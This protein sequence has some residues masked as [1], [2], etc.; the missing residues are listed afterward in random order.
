MRSEST[1]IA[2]RWHSP[3]DQSAHCEPL[4]PDNGLRMPEEVRTGHG[5]SHTYLSGPRDVK[6]HEG[7]PAESGMTCGS[8][9]EAGLIGYRTRCLAGRV[10]WH[11]SI[12]FQWLLVGVACTG[13][14]IGADRLGAGTHALVEGLSSVH[15]RPTTSHAQQCGW[16]FPMLPGGQAFARP[17]SRDKQLSTAVSVRRE[18]LVR[19]SM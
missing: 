7:T 2:C 17:T 4:N 8:H 5:T 10:G 18:R 19:D 12:F 3:V 9:E 13:T 16:D 15:N 6:G 1:K 14:L 11:L